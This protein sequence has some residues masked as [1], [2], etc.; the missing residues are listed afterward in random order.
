M[1]VV[2]YDEHKECSPL[3]TS[4]V[5]Q[6][7]FKF[8]DL[9]Q[10]NDP[11]NAYKLPLSVI[12]HIDLNAFFAQVEQVRLQ[13]TSEDPVVCVQWSSLIA[14]S[15]AARKYGIGR[16]DNV[17]T[18]RQKCPDVIL[19]HAAVFKKGEKHWAYVPGLPSQFTH[20]VLLDPYRREG[21]KIIKIFK[22]N[23]DMVEKASVDES[24]MDFGRLVYFKLMELFPN[25][26]SGIN[27]RLNETMPSIPT[28]LPKELQWVGEIVNN[29]EE[30]K[31]NEHDN[32]VKGG[33]DVEGYII[34]DWDDICMLIGS[35]IIFDIRMEV[36][37]ILGYT[38]SGG[39]GRNKVLS[40]LAG[41]LFKP[42]NQAIVRNLLINRFLN[43]FQLVDITGMGGKIGDYILQK[44]EVPTSR[45]VSSITFIRENYSNLRDIENGLNNDLQLSKK[46]WDL[47]H[48][49]YAN[50]LTL[51][52]ELKSMMSRKNFPGKPVTTWKDAND[53]IMVFAGDLYNRMIEL[54]DESMNISMLQEN[55]EKPNIR[56]PKTISLQYGTAEYHTHSKQA[57]IG[58]CRDLEKLRDNIE[59]MAKR[60]LQDLL[61][62]FQGM[63]DLNDG[64]KL[65]D[66]IEMGKI[67]LK[68]LPCTSM[69]LTIS[70][71]SKT[72]QTSLIDTFLSKESGHVAKEN[73]TAPPSSPQGL[74]KESTE[75]RGM[76]MYADETLN[77]CTG[78]GSRK[79]DLPQAPTNNSGKEIAEKDKEYINSLFK[80]FNSDNVHN[81][82]QTTD[83]ISSSS[84]KKTLFTK[85]NGGGKGIVD[86]L[87]LAGKKKSVA[88]NGNGS[89]LG[90]T[91][92]GNK[93]QSNIIND[94]QESSMHSNLN[95][96]IPSDLMATGKCSR[97]GISTN[98]PIEHHD[99]HLAMDLSM[100]LNGNIDPTS[101]NTNF[102]KPLKSNKV[103]R[104]KPDKGQT[105]LPF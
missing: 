86:Q 64:I 79:V 38:T 36:Y 16:M 84:T 33:N 62:T 83:S 23:C 85:K 93:N 98:D 69:S 47:I 17:S 31:L 74:Y 12:G 95:S 88:A 101:Q 7:Q 70:N 8:R 37:K 55:K 28:I 71:F 97:C 75:K 29:D 48:G 102:N 39:V 65:K 24:Y 51:K 30:E 67:G 15:Y 9:S 91:P 90:S 61:D 63:K 5:E 26:L 78:L 4:P 100:R 40:K 22:Q 81:E 77:N 68:I 2:N 14:V 43:Q 25:E 1:S 27:H 92:L 3:V 45:D 52:I 44:L 34:K 73:N 57:T 54:D 11:L 99:F 41:G 80:E 6:S 66:A 76:L 103:K 82:S 21:R 104:R 56:R 18:A 13:L 72:S 53:W 105:K 94:L 20:K 35:K 60:L 96:E 42:D 10:L 49:D 32:L 50:E 89:P 46:V 59:M 19:A 58:V 87:N